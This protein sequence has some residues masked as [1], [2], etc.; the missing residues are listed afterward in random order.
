MTRTRMP[1]SRPILPASGFPSSNASTPPVNCSGTDW[2]LRRSHGC[3]LLNRQEFDEPDLWEETWRLLC[4]GFGVLL[5]ER[6]DVRH[7]PLNNGTVHQ[8][9]VFLVLEVHVHF[10]H[11]VH[12]H[13]RIRYGH[14]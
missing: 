7:A 1:K 12:P 2:N 6:E 14:G 10:L 8:A 11:G 13:A 3:A 5:E 4:C 9:R